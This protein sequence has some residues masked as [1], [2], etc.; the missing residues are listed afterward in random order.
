MDKREKKQK[1]L[2]LI[3]SA[4]IINKWIYIHFGSVN[5]DFVII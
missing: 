2:D 1:I 4:K 3:I 5:P